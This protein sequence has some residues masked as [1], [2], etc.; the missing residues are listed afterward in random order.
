MPSQTTANRRLARYRTLLDEF[1]AEAAKAAQ[2]RRLRL[3]KTIADARLAKK[4]KQR[5]LAA[6]VSVDTITVSRWER[7]QHS[8]DVDK[9]ELIARAL[10]KPLVEFLI[11]QGEEMPAPANGGRRRSLEDRLDQLES[12]VESL[13]GKVDLL[14]QR[15]AAPDD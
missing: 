13:G 10:D 7:G 2:E 8:P 6:A 15:L 14:S 1:M 11:D 12:A 3:G 9:L 5:Q 4:W